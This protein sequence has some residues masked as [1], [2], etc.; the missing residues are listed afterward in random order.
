MRYLGILC[1]LCV[2]SGGN[3]RSHVPIIAFCAFFLL[4][5]Q[6]LGQKQGQA[7]IDSMLQ[8]LPKLTNDT[9][10]GRTYNRI[11]E[12]YFFIDI[13]KALKYSRLGLAHVTKMN[14]KRG[15][16]VFNSA[17]GI[18]VCFFIT[19][20]LPYTSKMMTNGTWLLRSII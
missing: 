14:W 11:V 1:N 5:F 8:E 17:I 2:T 16:A 20:P 13:D 10:K 4:S 7:K 15:I 3:T 6:G 19:E 18:L 12:E 9:L